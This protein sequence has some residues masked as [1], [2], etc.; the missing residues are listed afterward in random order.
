MYTLIQSTGVLVI[1]CSSSHCNF[2]SVTYLN[3]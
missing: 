3:H 1:A 2:N